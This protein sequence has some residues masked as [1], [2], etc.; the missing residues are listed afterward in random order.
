MR[1][2]GGIGLSNGRWYVTHKH[3]TTPTEEARK[4]TGLYH[5]QMRRLLKLSRG[6]PVS[7]LDLNLC[8]KQSVLHFRRSIEKRIPWLRIIPAPDGKITVNDIPR[9]QQFVRG[10]A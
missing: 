10:H 5:V 3:T 7:E 8:G 6:E 1:N 2:R 9:L 4:S